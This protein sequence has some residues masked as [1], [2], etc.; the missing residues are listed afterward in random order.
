MI[1]PDLTNKVVHLTK[2]DD[3]TTAFQTLWSIVNERKLRGGNGFIKG[4]YRCVCFCE[5]P[6]SQLALVLANRHAAGF[7][8]RPLGVMFSK[9]FVYAKGARP[10]IYGPDGDFD[11]LP[12][13][14]KYR[15][16]RYDPMR[17][18]PVDFT[19]EREWRLHA[20]E[21]QFTAA[22]VTVVCPHRLFVDQAYEDFPSLTPAE[23]AGNVAGWHF[24]V[25]EDLGVDIPIE[26]PEQ[27]PTN[28]NPGDFI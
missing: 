2:G 26:L 1:R 21:M 13:E 11:T 10:V 3:D 27:E 8:Y 7:K 5:T 25:L 6:L 17:A 18:P 15:H 14:L 20:D 24:V 28:T 22:D 19:W 23:Q 16:V 4:G 12:E 9:Q